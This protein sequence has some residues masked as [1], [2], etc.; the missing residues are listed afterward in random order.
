MESY[1]AFIARK[2]GPLRTDEGL[3]DGI[4]E[5]INTNLFGFQRK[6]V[7][8]AL[9]KRKAAVFADTGLGKSRI[10]LAYADVISRFEKICDPVLNAQRMNKIFCC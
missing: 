2:S 8:W 7:Q 5:D 4:T 10:E 3:A 9:L 1:A 6:V